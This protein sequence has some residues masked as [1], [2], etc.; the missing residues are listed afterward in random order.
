M[1]GG[2]DPTSADALGDTLGRAAVIGDGRAASA[3][4]LQAA[5]I[6]GGRCRPAGGGDL[7]DAVALAV[8]EEPVGGGGTAERALSAGELPLVI[9]GELRANGRAHACGAATGRVAGHVPRHIVARCPRRADGGGCTSALL[10]KR[11]SCLQALISAESAT[12]EYNWRVS[13]GKVANAARACCAV[14]GT[15]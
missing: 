14:S 9:V 1:G 11:A 15:V 2:D 6:D 4:L 10:C 13:N 5:H 12:S 7:L 3:H 8:V